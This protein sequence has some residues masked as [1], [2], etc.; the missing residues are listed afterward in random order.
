M[1][2]PCTRTSRKLSSRTMWGMT[3]RMMRLPRRCLPN[4]LQSFEGFFRAVQGV[5]HVVADVFGADQLLK[6]RLPDQPQRLFPGA[7]ENQLAAA[8]FQ[9]SRDFFQSEETGGIERRHI[10]QPQNHHGRELVNIFG[11]HVNLVGRAE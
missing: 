6:L 1:P 4:R 7:T 11:D 10:S 3:L 5:L 2:R 9:S 8:R